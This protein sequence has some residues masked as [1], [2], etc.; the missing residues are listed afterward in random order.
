MLHSK[1]SY[2]CVVEFDP[3]I[4]LKLVFCPRYHSIERTAYWRS[5]DFQN[6]Y[7][8]IGVSEEQGVLRKITL[9]LIKQISL[10]I[11]VL[12]EIKLVPGVPAFEKL[13]YDKHLFFDEV[14]PLKMFV[15]KD[16]LQVLFFG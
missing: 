6:Q 1:K 14:V 10:E 11:R 4:A 13:N 2:E 7:I 16:K 3:Y 8:E 5:G 15:G 12:P 9:E